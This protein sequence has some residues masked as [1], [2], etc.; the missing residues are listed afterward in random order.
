MLMKS[1]L[2][3]LPLNDLFDPIA[4]DAAAMAALIPTATSI[5]EKLELPDSAQL[6]EADFE[7]SAH[8]I[9]TNFIEFKNFS[10][11]L[12]RKHRLA[13]L[14][15]A[16]VFKAEALKLDGYLETAFMKHGVETAANTDGDQAINAAVVRLLTTVANEKE[17]DRWDISRN[18]TAIAG[19]EITC[20]D[21]RVDLTFGTVDRV[22]TL[23]ET[24]SRSGLIKLAHERRKLAVCLNIPQGPVVGPELT[25]PTNKDRAAPIASQ[26]HGALSSVIAESRAEPLSIET[27]EAE[28]GS[29]KHAPHTKLSTPPGTPDG[30]IFIAKVIRGQFQLFGPVAN[31]VEAAEYF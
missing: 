25:A 24:S 8:R 2:N 30:L 22:L 21:H 10:L 18:A 31:P 6:S 23:V 3:K 12:A 7:A 4:E 5:S 16:T 14:A 11:S 20:A 27:S 9:R 13:L 15:A 1:K 19:I 17:P 26:A 29:N 28:F